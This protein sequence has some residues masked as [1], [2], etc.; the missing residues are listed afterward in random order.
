M[1]GKMEKVT[2]KGPESIIVEKKGEET[3][4]PI[5]NKIKRQIV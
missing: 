3:H 4:G 1:S 2:L 5:Y